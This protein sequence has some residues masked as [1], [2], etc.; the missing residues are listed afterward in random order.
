VARLL[1]QW[2]RQILDPRLVRAVGQTDIA[3]DAFER[4]DAGMAFGVV[5]EPFYKLMNAYSR[6]PT[7]K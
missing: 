4:T 6:V 7:S 3:L 2:R 5:N 1:L